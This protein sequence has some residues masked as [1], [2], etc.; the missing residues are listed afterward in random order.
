MLRPMKEMLLTIEN[1]CHYTCGLTGVHKI[2]REVMDALAAV[3]RE[4]F[5]PANMKPYAYDNS[6]LPIGDGQTISQPFIVA[7]MT[8]LLQP[9]KN[10][11]ILEIGA[12]SGYQAAVLAKLAKKIYTVEI[13]APLAEKAKQRLKRLGYTNVEVSHDDGY[14]GL[15]EHAPF[16]G[17]IV[18]AAASHIPPPLKDQLKPG[19]RLVIPVGLPYM[20]QQLMMVEKDAEGSIFT[21][22]VL[23]VSFVPLTG[24]HTKDRNPAWT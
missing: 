10:D 22:S 19:G 4:D 11:V 12:G 8:H 24:D 13:I 18:T 3:P 1:E 15:P 7:L 20:P 23:A 17:I 6:P 5:V 9:E 14:Y 2:S 21:N 16:D